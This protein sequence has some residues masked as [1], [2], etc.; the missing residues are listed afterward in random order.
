MT[1]SN[2][3]S[4]IVG[5]YPQFAYAGLHKSLP[6]EWQ[7]LQWVTTG[8]SHEFKVVEEALAENFL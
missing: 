4:K 6:Q 2:Y 3:A 5:R 1:C 8:L 7:F